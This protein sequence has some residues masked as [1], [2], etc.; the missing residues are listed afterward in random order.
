MQFDRGYKSHYF[1][2][3]NSTMTAHLED[4]L[5]LIA[6]KRFTQIKELLPIFRR[7]INPKQTIVDYRRRYR[8]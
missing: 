3:N 6:D 7:C 8:W 2:T 4:P 5:I 1:V